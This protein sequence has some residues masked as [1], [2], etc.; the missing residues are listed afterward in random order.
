MNNMEEL[1]VL[2]IISKLSIFGISWH[3]ACKP[4]VSNHE[5]WSNGVLAHNFETDFT[6]AGVLPD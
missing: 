5:T 6:S 2:E 4:I 1:T 3:E